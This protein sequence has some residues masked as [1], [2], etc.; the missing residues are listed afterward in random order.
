M[1]VEGDGLRL[2][3]G[4]TLEI[5]VPNSGGY[6]DPIERDRGSGALDVLDGFTTV[7]LAERDYGVVI[8]AETL[9]VDV[10]ATRRLRAERASALAS[11]V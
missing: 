8:D 4:D 6:G 10:E 3:A 11:R 9:S 2:K 1:A 5:T 7:E